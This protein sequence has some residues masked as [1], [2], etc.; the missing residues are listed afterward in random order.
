MDCVLDCTRRSYWGECSADELIEQ[1]KNIA[2][3]LL[4]AVRR[5][6][7]IKQVIITSHSDS[8]GMLTPREDQTLP[9]GHPGYVFNEEDWTD[10]E[11]CLEMQSP[12]G[13]YIAGQTAVEKYALNWALEQPNIKVVSLCCGNLLGN[14]VRTND[15]MDT[16]MESKVAPLILGSLKE[17]PRGYI[18]LTHTNDAVNLHVFAM[19]K[20]LEGRYLCVGHQVEWVELVDCMRKILPKIGKSLISGGQGPPSEVLPDW[21]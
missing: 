13:A 15:K 18:R 17:I 20:K 16:F 11:K 2:A 9:H 10:M 8:C 14:V 5:A 3:I 21:T 6:R 1:T 7:S 19:E 12:Y 4:D